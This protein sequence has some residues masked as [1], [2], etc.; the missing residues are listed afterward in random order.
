[1]EESIQK[2]IE[3]YEIKENLNYKWL[4]SERL[5]VINMSFDNGDKQRIR[6]ALMTTFIMMTPYIKCRFKKC[7]CKRKL[8]DLKDITDKGEFIISAHEVYATLLKIMY[9]RD[10]LFTE[11]PVTLG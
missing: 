1:M 7:R 6:S 3:Y 10:M 11:V 9:E 8:Y 2:A 4:L 5:M